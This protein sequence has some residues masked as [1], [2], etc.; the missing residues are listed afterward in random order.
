MPIT[1]IKWDKTMPSSKRQRMRPFGLHLCLS[2]AVSKRWKSRKTGAGGAGEP[3]QD[4]AK[5][6]RAKPV[7]MLRELYMRPL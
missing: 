3:P 5:A 2:A 1:L 4:E 6:A 7:V